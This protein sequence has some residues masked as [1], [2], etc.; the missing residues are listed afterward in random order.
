MSLFGAEF[1][2]TV[3]R[4]LGVH[5]LPPID[6]SFRPYGYLLLATEE[7]ATDLSQNSELQNS[8]GAKNMLLTPSKLK[9][10][11][12]WISTDG[13]A[14]GCLGLEKE[15]WF[16]PWALLC[17][18]K[19]KSLTLG[20]N[21]LQA[22]AT[23]I[24]CRK[25]INL[26][27]EEILIPDNLVVRAPSGNEHEIKFSYLVIA[28][29][30]FSQKV[31]EMVK[32]GIGEDV[33]E[34]PLPVEPR[35]RFVYCFN[36]PEGPGLNTPLTIDPSGTYFRRE[37]LTGNFICGRSPE[38][39]EEPAPEDL[40]C[41]DHEFFDEKIWPV[42]ATRVK[43]FEKLKVNSAWAGF[44]EFNT[45]DANGVVGAHPYYENILFATGFSGHGIQH[46]PAV[47]R[48]VAELILAGQYET[49]DLSRLGFHRFLQKEPLKEVNIV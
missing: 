47:G 9:D 40:S 37:N 48:A 6:V 29:G 49:I 42:L 16:D 28:A 12:P 44:Y 18:L 26:A 45:F 17:A 38:P 25:G 11:F 3:N 46:S 4:H 10:L 43:A 7:G 32:I 22:E 5:E 14:L 2:R 23:G 31:A 24:N 36:C 41:V 39:D 21:Y 15:G 8:L 35:K 13:L 33:L 30:A 20:V 19:T 27:G 34:T 1:I